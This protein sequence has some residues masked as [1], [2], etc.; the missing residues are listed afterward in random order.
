[1]PLPDF[2]PLPEM[3]VASDSVAGVIFCDDAFFFLRHMVHAGTHLRLPGGWRREPTE[4]L[5]VCCRRLVTEELRHVAGEF[6]RQLHVPS[7][8][9]SLT[10]EVGQKIGE[11]QVG[12]LGR[13]HYFSITGRGHSLFGGPWSEPHVEPSRLVW[14]PYVWVRSAELVTQPIQPTEA[15]VICIEARKRANQSPEPTSGLAPGRG[16]S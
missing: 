9:E 14:R 11:H 2:P 10:V 5:E 4:S 13:M 7:E 16:S 6:A 12:R 3:G 8:V 15:R 1:M